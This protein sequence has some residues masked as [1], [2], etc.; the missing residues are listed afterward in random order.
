MGIADDFINSFFEHNPQAQ[1]G[2]FGAADHPNSEIEGRLF[3]LELTSL[4]KWLI[5][6]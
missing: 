5:V 4:S 2:E 3:R 1:S 6:I